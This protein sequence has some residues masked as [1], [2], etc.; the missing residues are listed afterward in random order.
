VSS[1]A[2][3]DQARDAALADRLPLAAPDVE[4]QV[5]GPDPDPASLACARNRA[6]RDPVRLVDPGESIR[7]RD[8]GDEIVHSDQPRH[9]AGRGPH[10]HRRAR[11]LLLDAATDHHRDP[12]R[13]QQC[14]A[15]I[16]GD[17]RDRDA[18]VRNHAAQVE[19]DRGLAGAV[20]VVVGLVEQEHRGILRERARECE[21]A[22]LAARERRSAPRGESPDLEAVERQAHASLHLGARE[23]ASEQRR[24]HVVRHRARERGR[25]LEHQ[26]GR[27][28]R[29][30]LDAPAR[31]G[32][33]ARERAQERAL[34]RAVRSEHDEHLA[35][36]QREIVDA[37]LERTAARAQRAFEVAHGEH[38]LA[39]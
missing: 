9:R 8:T 34:A 3:V 28:V 2:V 29:R 38:G 16:V 6:E 36:P 31:A 24:A 39:R 21:S 32:L 14:A 17:E 26:R 27:A 37:Q 19:R 18:R 11:A 25:A 1:E 10:E 7:L 15:Q 23:S 12:V 22:Q 4:L 5:L 20:E 30:A 35:A 13:E 33:E